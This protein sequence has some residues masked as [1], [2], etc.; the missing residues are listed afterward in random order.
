LSLSNPNSVYQP[1]HQALTSFLAEQQ[2]DARRV[3]HGRG[4]LF[5]GL[6]HINVDWYSPVLL[7]SG[8]KEIENVDELIALAKSLDTHNQIKSIVYQ[9]RSSKG[10]VSEV[11]W[12]EEHP[13]CIVTENGLKFEVQPGVRQNA[14]FFLDMRPLR[15]WL[16]K[17]SEGKNVL[18]LF[19]YTCSLSVAAMAGGARQVV[20]VDMSKPS[21][22][23]GKRNHGLNDQDP[24]SV[25]SI[26]HNLFRSWGKV[27][28]SGP[29]DLLLIDPPTR[30]VGS[31]DI[32]KDYVTVLKK[33]N[34]LCAP[35]ADIVATV[36]S[37]YLSGDYL[38]SLMQRYQSK[39]RLIGEME[40]SPEFVDKYP[41][42]GLKI[43][44]FRAPA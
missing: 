22:D 24:R 33:L 28:Q 6:E 34:N 10:A 39:V 27:R 26:P 32:E 1:L 25:K 37:P 3:F 36:N 17:Y 29:Y 4:H 30:Q 41:E 23:W 35:N 15:G 11:K 40:A 31:F 16:Q 13:V 38:P 21:I 42:R 8:Y 7:V 19:A 20:N 2:P 14:G 18:N 44:Y 43:F 5:E 12:G 9:L